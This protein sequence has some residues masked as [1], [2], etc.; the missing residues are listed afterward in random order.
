MVVATIFPVESVAKID[1]VTVEIMTEEANVEVEENVDGA[2]KIVEL[3]KVDVAAKFV[4]LLN[5]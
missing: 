3:L 4:E 2:L 5:V 1:D